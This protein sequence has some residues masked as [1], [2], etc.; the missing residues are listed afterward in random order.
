MASTSPAWA[1]LVTSITPCRPRATRSAKKVF[2]AGPVSAVATF[3]PRTSRC[4]SA[5]TPVATSTAALITR[6]ASRTFIVNASAATN[7]N[8]PAS[9]RRRVRNAPTWASRSAAIRE[10]CDFDKLV[11]PKDWTSLSIRRVETPSR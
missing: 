1:S 10:T 2:H 3:T 8:G 11:I 9:S 4:P 6:P 7:V 5:L